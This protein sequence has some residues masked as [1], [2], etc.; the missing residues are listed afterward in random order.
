MVSQV[1]RRRHQ[2]AGREVLQTQRMI[3]ESGVQVGLRR[4]ASVAGFGKQGEIGQLQFFGQRAAYG[5]LN[6][7]LVGKASGV[8]EAGD[9]Q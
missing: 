9:E 7:A 1:G 2:A 8:D 3:L 4:V 5:L 6:G